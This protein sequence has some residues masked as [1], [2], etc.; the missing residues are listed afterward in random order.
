MGKNKK[1]KKTN[2]Y[3]NHRKEMADTILAS[4]RATIIAGVIAIIFGLFFAFITTAENEPV[5]YSEAEKYEGA[6][7]KYT[8]EKNYCTIHFQDGTKLSVYPHTAKWEFH[9]KMESLEKGTVLYILVNPNNNYVAQIKTDTE[10][11]MNFEISQKEIKD[12]GKGYIGIG[13]FVVLCGVYLI[14]F[15]ILNGV[16]K[17]REEARVKNKK[18]KHIDGKDDDVIRYGDFS[19]KH[20]VLLEAKINEYK[21][22]YRRVKKTNE[23]V[24]NGRV[25]DEKKAL[26]EFPHNLSANVGGHIIEAGFDGNDFSYICFDGERIA[27]KRRII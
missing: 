18:G 26:I 21:I 4:P 19:K 27:Q 6:F 17:K 14:A 23:L 13:I 20:R 11:I 10:E 12:Y 1:K 15:G 7:E 5:A 25:Y 9:E 24:I 8:Y 2:S 22:C 3:Q 16:H